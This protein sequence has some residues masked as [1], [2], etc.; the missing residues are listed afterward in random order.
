MAVKPMVYISRWVKW[1]PVISFI[2]KEGLKKNRLKRVA[3]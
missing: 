1:H 3:L 2:W